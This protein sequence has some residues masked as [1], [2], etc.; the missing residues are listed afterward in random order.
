MPPAD[1]IKGIINEKKEILLEKRENIK[2]FYK[3]RMKKKNES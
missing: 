1:K 2:E 3:D